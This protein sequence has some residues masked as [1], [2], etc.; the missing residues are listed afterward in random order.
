ML[1][2]A[3]GKRETK[4]SARKRWKIWESGIGKHSTNLWV[5]PQIVLISD[6]IVFCTENE[7]IILEKYHINRRTLSHRFIHKKKF[8]SYHT[9]NVPQQTYS[10]ILSRDEAN[11]LSKPNTAAQSTLDSVIRTNR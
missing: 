8:S 4:M 2:V 5:I 9:N 1:S 10:V 3:K 7:S 11:H 6:R